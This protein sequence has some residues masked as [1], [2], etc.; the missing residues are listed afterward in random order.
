MEKRS[1]KPNEAKLTTIEDE[2]S[3]YNYQKDYYQHWLIID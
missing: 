3:M 1:K 2:Q